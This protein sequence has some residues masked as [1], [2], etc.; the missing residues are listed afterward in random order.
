MR[1]KMIV[2]LQPPTPLLAPRFGLGRRRC[3]DDESKARLDLTSP[4]RPQGLKCAEVTNHQAMVVD[5]DED[6]PT[7]TSLVVFRMRRHPCAATSAFVVNIRASWNLRRV[8]I[9]RTDHFEPKWTHRTSKLPSSISSWMGRSKRYC[10][11]PPSAPNSGTGPAI[12][13]SAGIG[14]VAL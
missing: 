6:I 1:G 11:A 14:R 2:I 3:H 13:T 4:G 7:G 10:F 5:I 9:A 12:P 8:S